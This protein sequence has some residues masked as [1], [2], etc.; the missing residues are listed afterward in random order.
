MKKNLSFKNEEKN[1]YSGVIL[2][3]FAC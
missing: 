3:S 2:P 1:F